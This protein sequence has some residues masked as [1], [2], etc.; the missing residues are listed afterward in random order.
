MYVDPIVVKKM[1]VNVDGRDFVV[2]DLHG[3]YD[4]L[5]KLLKYVNFDPKKDRLFSTGDLLDRG[6]KSIECLSL[7]NKSWFFPVMGNHEEL[8][9]N[10]VKMLENKQADGLSIE[11]VELISKVKGQVKDVLKLPLIYEI[12]HLIY[13][14]IYVIHGEILPEHI[15]EKFDNI[16]NELLQKEY[17][18][19]FEYMKKN[20]YSKNIREFFNR[21]SD[22]KVDKKIMGN[23]LR[24]KLLWSR[25]IITSFYKENKASIDLGDFSFMKNYSFEQETKVFC[26]HNIVPF[27]MKI[28]Q[29]HYIDTGA[30]L[31]YA[32][33]EINSMLFSQF[34][35]EFFALTLTELTTGLSYGCITSPQNRGEILK[36][37]NS[38]YA[39]IDF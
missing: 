29:Q 1:P 25:K 36:L 3:C 11:D 10:K 9:L 23:S 7:L 35:H 37:A 28:G 6:P 15:N 32:D 24:Q 26:G 17:V 19:I 4:E 8:L 39:P 2:G 34:G 31:G 14:K 5:I 16:E 18:A 20:D 22:G 12:E 13:N 21:F 38:I 33:K 27:P 30:A